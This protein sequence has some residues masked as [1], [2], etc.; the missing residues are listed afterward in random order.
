VCDHADK[1][2]EADKGQER[3]ANGRERIT[4]LGRQV[5]QIVGELIEPIDA[6]TG[7]QEKK[8]GR[9]SDEGSFCGYSLVWKLATV[10]V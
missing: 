5:G 2:Y 4:V 10:A 3:H 1:F 7:L 6:R 9:P 8:Q